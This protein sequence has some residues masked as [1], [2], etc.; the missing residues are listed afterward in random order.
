MTNATTLLLWILATLV[1]AAVVV[2]FNLWRAVLYLRPGAIRVEVDAPADQMKLPES[3]LPMAAQLESLGFRRL[4]THEEKAPLKRATLSYDFVLPSARTFATLYLSGSQPLLYL[5]T[6]IR[7]G[8]YVLSANF[9]RPPREEPAYLAGGVPGAEPERLL[10]LHQRR[11]EGRVAEGE[12]TLEARVAAAR[13]WFT[14]P[15]RKDVR[16][17]NA[18]GFFWTAGAILVVLALFFG[19]G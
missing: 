11:L 7:G 17:Q 8:G 18:Q 13:D 16:Q 12:T 9:R 10:K 2:W 14:G 15:G 19:N 5:F 1:L 6:P 3:L 4:G